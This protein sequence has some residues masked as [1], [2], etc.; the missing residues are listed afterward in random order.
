[1]FQV[2]RNCA[3]DGF[4]VPFLGGCVS[5]LFFSCCLTTGKVGIKHRG[6]PTHFPAQ[7]F[8]RCARCG[9]GCFVRSGSRGCQALGLPGGMSRNWQ[10]VVRL[11]GCPC[12]TEKG[13]EDTACHHQRQG[14]DSGVRVQEEEDV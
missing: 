2:S 9:C 4:S 7:T 5:L 10:D 1:M 11:V 14:G 6:D 3:L 12:L 8:A 13:K